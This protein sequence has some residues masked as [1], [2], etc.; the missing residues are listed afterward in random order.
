MS[1]QAARACRGTRR[2]C[3]R[4]RTASAV[5]SLHVGPAGWGAGSRGIQSVESRTSV[6]YGSGTTGVAFMRPPVSETVCAQ[7]GT[8]GEVSLT[9]G[10]AGV[11]FGPVAARSRRFRGAWAWCPEAG[12]SVTRLWFGCKEPGVVA[13]GA[14]LEPAWDALTGRCIAYLP[15]AIGLV[16]VIASR[17]VC[18]QLI[19][20]STSGA[21][22]AMPKYWSHISTTATAFGVARFTSS[23]STGFS[24]VSASVEVVLQDGRG[25]GLR[26]VVGR[27]ARRLPIVR[28]G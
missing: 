8:G 10:G 11:W 24:S 2:R 12:D 19:S 18:N 1:P 23:L 25:F 7:Q 20:R 26:V 3:D 17:A 28:R 27:M 5:G 14:G 21:V 22:R 4:R 9:C 16:H 15:P 13:G 6:G